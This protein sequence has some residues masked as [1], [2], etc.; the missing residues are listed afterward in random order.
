LRAAL[1]RGAKLLLKREMPE[2]GS[3]AILTS[4]DHIYVIGK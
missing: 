4:Y 1:K 2:G 3:I